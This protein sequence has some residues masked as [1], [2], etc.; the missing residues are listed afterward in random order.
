MCVC[1]YIYVYMC[2]CVYL[3][4]LFLKRNSKIMFSW[5]SDIFF[6][7]KSGELYHSSVVSAD[8]QI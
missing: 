6:F 1:V 5:Y 4:I 7:Q 2:I 3:Y 8:D